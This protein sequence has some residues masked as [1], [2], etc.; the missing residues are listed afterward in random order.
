M[1]PKRLESAQIRWAPVEP[2]GRGSRWRCRSWISGGDRGSNCRWFRSGRCSGAL[3]A[4]GRGS[5]GCNL[6][7]HPFLFSTSLRRLP[8]SDEGFESAVEL[9]LDRGQ[10]VRRL[11][12]L[13]LFGFR[14][15]SGRVGFMLRRFE[16]EALFA[17]DSLCRV[18]II[19]ELPAVP[20]R[21]RHI[22]RPLPEF[23]AIGVQEVGQPALGP[24][25][26]VRL[27]REGTELTTR[28]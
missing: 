16:S 7:F 12:R 4:S 22:A 15:A 24:T 2:G 11:L 8:L 5:L 1:Q 27:H 10:M 26:H 28:R 9:I 17:G 19:G 3:F 18:E 14:F 21:D 13:A 6:C 20:D 23:V 25:G